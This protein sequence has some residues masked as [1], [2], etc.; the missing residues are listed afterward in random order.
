M[1]YTLLP[2]MTKLVERNFIV[3]SKL[4]TLVYIDRTSDFNEALMEAESLIHDLRA[5]L[6]K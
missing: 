1:P 5:E 4:A 6:E 3:A 2:R